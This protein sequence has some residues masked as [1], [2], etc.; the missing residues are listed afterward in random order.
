MRKLLCWVSVSIDGY[1]EGPERQIDWHRVD[2]ELHSF[3]N[4]RLRQAGVL[5]EGRVTYEMMADFWPTADQDPDN[6]PVVQ[7]FADIWR[8]TPKIV[9]STTLEE[10]G[11][12]TTIVR[13]VVP[14]E[15]RVLKA[16]PGGDL[17]VGGGQLG[18]AFAKHDLIDEY[19]IF[20]HP[21]IL[22]TGRPLLALSYAPL[23]L[24]LVETKTFGNGVVML[25]YQRP[26]E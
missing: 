25:R 2:D 7:E 21:V 16:E 3:F 5:L 9:Y 15:V 12:N 23:A 8:D 26:E 20:V 4:D 18:S 17:V 24:R 14:E 19:W 13:G 1:I 11:W 6:T 10:T 22:G